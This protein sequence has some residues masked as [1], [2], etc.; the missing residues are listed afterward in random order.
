MFNKQ[1]I[2]YTPISGLYDSPVYV[3]LMNVHEGLMEEP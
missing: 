2:P 1:Y 3:H